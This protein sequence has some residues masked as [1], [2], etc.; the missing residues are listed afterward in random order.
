MFL[1]LEG[2][3][4]YLVNYTMIV[5]GFNGLYGQVIA[6]TFVALSLFVIIDVIKY[7]LSW[8]QELIAKSHQFMQIQ[9][10]WY[11]WKDTDRRFESIVKMSKLVT[12]VENCSQIE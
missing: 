8:L 9:Q 2:N 6:I 3:G 5:N 7:K 11:G 10:F 1:M 4:H 12:L